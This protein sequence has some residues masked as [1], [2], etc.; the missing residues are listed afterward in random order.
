MTDSTT[1]PLCRADQIL[2]HLCSQQE[3]IDA[4]IQGHLIPRLSHLLQMQDVE[5]IREQAHLLI[6]A[7]EDLADIN[8][9]QGE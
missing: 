6:G 1:K 8:I 7:L 2:Q 3:R 5:L 4:E 9:P